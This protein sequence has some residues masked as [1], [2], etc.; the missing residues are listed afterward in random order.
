MFIHCIKGIFFAE[1]ELKVKKFWTG[2]LAQEV[3]HLPCKRVQRP[4]T[5]KKNAKTFLKYKPNTPGASGSGLGESRFKA[6]LGKVGEILSQEYSA[7]K[8]ADRVP[9]VLVE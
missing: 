6:S 7:Q 9:Q 1:V 2:D 5:S 4:S 8:R 3:E